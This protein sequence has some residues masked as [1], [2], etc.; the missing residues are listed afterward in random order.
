MLEQMSLAVKP[1]T[2]NLNYTSTQIIPNCDTHSNQQYA[3]L[4]FIAPLSMWL[5]VCCLCGITA[6]LR[7]VHY[8]QLY[9][10]ADTWLVAW[11][12]A[13]KGGWPVGGKER[14]E[15]WGQESTLAANIDGWL[16]Q[17]ATWVTA[18]FSTVARLDSTAI[19]ENDGLL[20]CVCFYAS[21]RCVHWWIQDVRRLNSVISRKCRTNMD[22]F[23]LT[24]VKFSLIFIHWVWTTDICKD[25][26]LYFFPL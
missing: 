11:Q 15:S 14:I 19:Q 13:A 20:S 9:D 26:W 2:P 3:H 7:I 4:V 1:R 5:D 22:D 23:C 17:T 25:G 24:L 16:R 21:W 12:E 6:V 8:N 10:S 18:L